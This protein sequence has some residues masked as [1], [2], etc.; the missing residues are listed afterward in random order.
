M[1]RSFHWFPSLSNR[2]SFAFLQNPNQHQIKRG[3]AT[4]RVNEQGGGDGGGA[5]HVEQDVL[6]LLAGGDGYLLEPHDGGHLGARV[7]LLPRGSGGG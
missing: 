3:R 1:P 4:G 5:S 7:L 6:V 2:Y